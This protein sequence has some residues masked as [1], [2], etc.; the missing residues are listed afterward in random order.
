MAR[1]FK[2]GK[3]GGSGDVRAVRIGVRGMNSQGIDG[4]SIDH[5]ASSYRIASSDGGLT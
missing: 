4:T 5:I 2:F 1:D 3:R